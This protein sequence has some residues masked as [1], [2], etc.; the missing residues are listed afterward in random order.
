MNARR[1]ARYWGCGT[2]LARDNAATICVSCRAR[3]RELVDHPPDVD[4]E[5]WRNPGLLDAFATQHIGQVSRAY[6]KHPQHIATYGRH[7]IPQEVLGRWLGLTQAQVSR[8]ENGHPVKH[9]DSLRH[10]ARTLQIPAHLLWFSAA[11]SASYEQDPSPT[12]AIPSTLLKLSA[13]HNSARE[14]DD[15]A[16][17]MH[18]LRAADRQI[19][20]GHLYATVVRYL[21][22]EVASKLFGV[23]HSSDGRL[24]FT[25][26]AALTEMAG[27]MARDTGRDQA[28]ARHFTRSLDLAGVGGD[29][30]LGVHILA[31]MSHLA[32][33]RRMPHEGI[34]LARRGRQLLA[35]GPRQP[36]LEA[37]VLAMEARGFAA[38][39]QSEECTRRLAEAEHA[40][41]DVAEEER[42]RWTSHFDE[43]SLA[44]ESARCLSQLGDLAEAER[45]AQRIIMLRPG[46]RARSRALGQLILIAV[47]IRRGRTDEACIIAREVL[48]TTRELGSYLVNQQL[49]DLRRLL[50]PHA[51]NPSVTDLLRCLDEA[52]HSRMRPYRW[53]GDE[54]S[55]PGDD[56]GEMW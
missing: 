55:R 3:S 47:L 44:S 45:Q 53:L 23:D 19:G 25:A 51:G 40:L 12:D 1:P 10:W 16:A 6:R 37:R 26:A 35:R 43:A 50:G 46:D 15:I 2:R 29:R 41:A 9:L 38:L 39:R 21:Q 30:Q 22:T 20:G 13:E 14:E 32:H 34:H 48:D 8:I 31:S 33:H 42:S 52:S 7:G 17:A 28:A 49:M 54:R 18:S 27:W 56:L 5:F 4:G 11:I 24:A 36:E